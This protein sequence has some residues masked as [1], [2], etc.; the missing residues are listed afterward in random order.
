M[1]IMVKAS[2]LGVGLALSL[3][4]W[5]ALADVARTRTLVYHQLTGQSSELAVRGQPVLSDSGDG[6]AFAAGSPPR[7]FSL[8]TNGTMMTIA[9]L[10]FWNSLKAMIPLR[11][12][13]RFTDEHWKR[14]IHGTRRIKTQSKQK[15]KSVYRKAMHLKLRRSR[16]RCV[17]WNENY[18]R[19]KHERMVGNLLSPFWH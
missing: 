1:K 12:V 7:L 3:C 8:K 16:P 13:K 6:A 19:L 15:R 9:P 14:I 18:R 17:N 11:I 2:F 5:S 10:L 4:H